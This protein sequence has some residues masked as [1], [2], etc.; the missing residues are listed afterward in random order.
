MLALQLKQYTN[1]TLTH[2]L[3]SQFIYQ[4]IQEVPQLKKQELIIQTKKRKKTHFLYLFLTVKKRPY[5]KKYYTSWKM[6]SQKQSLL[7][8]K[9]K[10]ISW[11]VE[12]PTKIIFTLLGHMLFNVIP[13]QTDSEKTILNSQ[14]H[15]LDITIPY[16]P[17]TRS[18]MKLQSKNNYLIDIPLTW[19][20]Q[21]NNISFFQK[22][23]ILRF[24]KVIKL[25]DLKR[26]EI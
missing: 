5:V 20:W 23:F 13:T 18:T 12:I 16:A 3:S 19:R 14:N 21:W 4:S 6:S 15:Q 22:I 11:K 10:N 24:F 1:K 17:L 2:I 26:L 7:Q 25:Q 9:P 8:S